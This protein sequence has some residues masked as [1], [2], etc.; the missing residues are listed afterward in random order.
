MKETLRVSSRGQITLPASIRKRLGL[1]GGDVV[2]LEERANE[3][4]LKPGTVVEIEHYSDEQIAQWT[5]A[6]ALSEPERKRLERKIVRR[7]R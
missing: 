6:D 2:I 7:K 1:R 3:V 5:E 4:V